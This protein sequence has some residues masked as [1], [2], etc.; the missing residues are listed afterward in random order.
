MRPRDP[1]GPLPTQDASAEPPTDAVAPVDEGNEGNCFASCGS[2]PRAPASDELP[3]SGDAG[4]ESA[5][6]GASGMVRSDV[7][8]SSGARAIPHSPQR[9]GDPDE[10]YRRLLS[11]EYLGCG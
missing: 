6:T 8:P 2:V 5:D 4:G 11:G 7:Q 3:A 10:G 9:A 1:E